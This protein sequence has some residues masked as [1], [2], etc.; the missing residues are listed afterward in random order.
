MTKYKLIF[1]KRVL[2]DLDKIPNKVLE[3]I[4]SCFDRLKSNPRFS[5]SK[6]L[7]GKEGFY[8]IRQGDYRIIY[9]ID[10]KNKIVRIL[11]VRQR[12]DVYRK[13]Y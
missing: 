1:E 6:K 10:D 7:S 2:K 3:G 8:R 13:L 9:D 5:G 4:L 11:L 12:K